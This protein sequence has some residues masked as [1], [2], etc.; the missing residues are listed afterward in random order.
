MHIN[1]STQGAEKKRSE[2]QGH[3]SYIE[4][5]GQPRLHETLTLPSP[6][7]KSDGKKAVPDDLSGVWKQVRL[8]VAVMKASS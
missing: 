6:Q 8:R 5:K 2:V 1:P 7:K 4:L 3:F